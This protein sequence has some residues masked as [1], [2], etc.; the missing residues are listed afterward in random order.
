V[1]S[2]LA[3]PRI[4]RSDELEDRGEADG[5]AGPRDANAAVLERLAQR[6]EH[7]AIEL[8]QLV[9][10]EDPTMGEAHFAGREARAAADHG[11]VGKGVVRSAKRARPPQPLAGSEQPGDASHDRDLERLRVVE[12]RQEAGHGPGQEGLARSR[13]TDQ[14]E[15]VA[16]RQGHL[17]RPAGERLAANLDQVGRIDRSAAAGWSDRAGRRH[18]DT[19][20]DAHASGGDG[21]RARPRRDQPDGVTQGLDGD[22][23]D[24]RDEP[25]LRQVGR[26]D[27]DAPMPGRHEHRGHGQDAGDGSYFSAQRELAKERPRPGGRADLP[28]ADQDAKGDGEVERGAA[29][30]HLGRGEVHRDPARRVIEPTVADGAANPLAGLGE[31]GVGKADDG[32]TR[33]AVGDVDLDADDPPVETGEGGREER[34]EHAADGT[35]AASIRA[36]PPLRRPS[37]RRPARARAR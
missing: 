23:L 22:G 37:R 28:V 33:Q 9:E 6:V 3:R 7:V 21:P 12:R 27:G 2:R 14:Q 19:S 31:S 15:V 1:Q 13:W 4:R 36:S 8:R 30:A 25:R 34:G 16:A 29:L 11:G 35:A 32:Q 20:R 10:E 26:W 24:S 18:G 5:S 17:E